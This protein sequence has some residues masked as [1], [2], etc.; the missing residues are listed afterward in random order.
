V[1]V[2]DANGWIQKCETELLRAVAETLACPIPPFLEIT[3]S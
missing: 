1:H 3:E 2:V